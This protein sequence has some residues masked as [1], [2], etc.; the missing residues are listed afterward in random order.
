MARRYTIHTP[1]VQH[2]NGKLAPSS[3]ICHNQPDSSESEVTFYYGYRYTSRPDMS[4]YALREKARNLAEH[5]YT[6]GEEAQKA[7]F[8]ECV[9]KADDLLHDA[10]WKY[11]IVRAFNR[12]RRYV[13]VWNYAIARLVKHGGHMPP[14]W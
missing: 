11:R 13:R 6:D 8:T 9:N 4:R 5:P 10:M 1:P 2:M 3:L 12:Q 14:D 7:L